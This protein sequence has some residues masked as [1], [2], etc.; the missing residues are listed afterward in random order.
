[1]TRSEWTHPVDDEIEAELIRVRFPCG[2]W[3]ERRRSVDEWWLILY[4][5]MHPAVGPGAVP[6][7]WDGEFVVFSDGWPLNVS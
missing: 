4:R 5:T 1:M 2:Q 7:G 6:R 3:L